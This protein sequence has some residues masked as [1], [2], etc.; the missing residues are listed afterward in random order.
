MVIES[1]AHRFPDN[2][3]RDVSYVGEAPLPATVGIWGRQPVAAA[4]SWWVWKEEQLTGRE[5]SELAWTDEK[6]LLELRVAGLPTQ[7]A[8]ETRPSLEPAVFCFW[9]ALFFP[10]LRDV[11][12][13]TRP[14][15]ACG[16]SLAV[17]S[18]NSTRVQE[19]PRN[20][21]GFWRQRGNCSLS[22][23]KKRQKHATTINNYS[24]NALF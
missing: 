13:E 9:R 7:L 24:T 20:D 12:F 3:S 5:L 10:T 16:S 21:P 11:I 22:E 23:L 8:A 18:E 1:K 14:A 15:G 17:P 2:F 19:W 4:F 6:Q